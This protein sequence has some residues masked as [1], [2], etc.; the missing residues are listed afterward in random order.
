MA[1]AMAHRIIKSNVEASL[2]HFEPHNRICDPVVLNSMS[3][4]YGHV[5]LKCIPRPD[6]IV[7]IFLVDIDHKTTVYMV[8]FLN[9]TAGN[10]TVVFDDIAVHMR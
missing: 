6:T 2:A 4:M 8:G 5:I 1:E 10:Y 7:T 9:R 3:T